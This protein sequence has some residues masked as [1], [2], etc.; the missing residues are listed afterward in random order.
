M[1]ELVGVRLSD[2]ILDGY[3]TEFPIRPAAAIGCRCTGCIRA[4]SM[5]S[6]TD[7]ATGTAL[8]RAARAN[9]AMAA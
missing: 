9:A 4:P 3:L 8:G 6:V 5:P 7:P 2:D 1:L